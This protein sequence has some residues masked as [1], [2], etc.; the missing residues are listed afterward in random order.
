MRRE[1]IGW[2]GSEELGEG[3]LEQGEPARLIA[4]VG[5]DPRDETGLETNAGSCRRPLDGGGQIVVRGD[6][7]GH[8]PDLEQLAELGVAQGIVEKVGPH[9]DDDPDTRTAVGC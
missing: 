5:D 1:E 8:H 6:G 7:Y 3:V 4:D 2:P 9:G